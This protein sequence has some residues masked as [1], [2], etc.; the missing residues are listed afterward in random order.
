MVGMG[1]GTGERGARPAGVRPGIA[2]GARDERGIGLVLVIGVTAAMLLI[3]SVS[4]VVATNSLSSA[5]THVFYEQAMAS[6]ETG[7]ESTLG[8]IQT[9]H[10]GGGEYSSPSDCTARWEWPST[11]PPTIAAERAWAEAAIA[12]MPASCVQRGGEGEY[13]AFRALDLAGTNVPVVYSMGWSPGRDAAE[14]KSRLIKADYVFGAYQPEFAVLTGGALQMLNDVTVTGPTA[15]GADVRSNSSF[16]GN[17]MIRVD[18]DIVASGTNNLAATCPNGQIAGVCLQNE[19]RAPLPTITAYSVYRSLASAMAGSWYDLCPDG[20][21]R[22]PDPARTSPCTG[23]IASAVTPYDGWDLATVS[24]IPTWTYSGGGSADA[25]IYYAYW[26]DVV[27]DGG[28]AD[29][30]TVTMIADADDRNGICALRGGDIEWRSGNVTGSVPGLVMVADGSL[31]ASAP[32]TA[33]GGMLAAGADV[34]LRNSTGTPTAITGSLLASSTCPAAVASE[35]N[36]NIAL[37]FDDSADVPVA[38]VLRT[39]SWLELSGQ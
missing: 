32:A 13:I 29:N 27:L 1:R 35:V 23:T 5:R 26:A 17:N 39:T 6:A 25:R 2:G 14:A 33:R 9:A 7:L 24:G 31:T 37:T 30:D 38:S 36:G 21:V 4:V 16:V 3:M 22:R 10:D 15:G 34:Q 28:A 12:G 20:T 19:S 18:G 8:L 11:D